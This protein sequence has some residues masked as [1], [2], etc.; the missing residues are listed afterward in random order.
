MPDLSPAAVVLLALGLAV[1]INAILLLSV[2]RSSLRQQIRLLR[3]AARR[4]RDPWGSEQ[5][6]LKEL[7][8]RVAELP[9]AE[10][11]STDDLRS[12]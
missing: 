9:E 7:S 1:L 5:Q 4:A 6:D 12:R 11:D 8:R 3:E 2:A 10:A